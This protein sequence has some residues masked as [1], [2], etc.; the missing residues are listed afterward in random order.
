MSGFETFPTNLP[1]KPETAESPKSP[2]EIKKIKNR[3]RYMGGHASDAAGSFFSIS[4]LFGGEYGLGSPVKGAEK[5][6]SE[7]EEIEKIGKA[8]EDEE[9]KEKK[10][11]GTWSAMD[12]IAKGLGALDDVTTFK[13]YTEYM[14]PGQKKILEWAEQ[15]EQRLE[16]ARKEIETEHPAE[17][18]AYMKDTISTL[19]EGREPG[20]SASSLRASVFY[21]P[22]MNAMKYFGRQQDM[23][24]LQKKAEKLLPNLGM[25]TWTRKSAFIDFPDSVRRVDEREIL[26]RNMKDISD[27][28]WKRKGEEIIETFI[29]RIE[30]KNRKKAEEGGHEEGVLRV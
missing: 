7:F 12:R 20:I 26:Q 17:Y 1:K 18:D 24:E 15:K 21:M 16:E 27:A 30:E 6:L 9:R 28:F 11:Q 5:A 2:E 22:Y 13:E 23:L 14:S 8:E 29:S 25:V 10:E 4:R 19:T 3:L